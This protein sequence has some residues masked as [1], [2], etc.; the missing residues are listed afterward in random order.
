[1]KN[2]FQVQISEIQERCITTFDTFVKLH[3]E[4]IESLQ[5]ANKKYP[6]SMG[7]L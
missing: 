6:L 1:M 5:Q 3:N 4:H 2:R 7:I